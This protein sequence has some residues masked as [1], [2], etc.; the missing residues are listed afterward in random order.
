VG[1]SLAGSFNS[2]YATVPGGLELGWG[3]DFAFA[4]FSESN[5][6]S[7]QSQSTFGLLHTAALRAGAFRYWLGVGGGLMVASQDKAPF[8][9]AAAGVDIPF[10]QQTGVQLR[11]GYASML[12]SAT[13][14]SGNR[15]YDRIGNPLDIHA[16]LFYRFR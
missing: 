6:V 3:L 15:T 2:R 7:S 11:I 14:Q 4:S 9:R 12:T 13:V 16:G 5:G 10:D 8:A 1:F